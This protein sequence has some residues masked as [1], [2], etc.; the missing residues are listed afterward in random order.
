MP[1]GVQKNILSIHVLVD[2]LSRDKRVKFSF[3]LDKKTGADE[4]ES[5][6]IH[7]KLF[8]RDD[9]ADD[10]DDPTINIDVVVKTKN[11]EKMEVTAAK[12]FNQAQT[13]RTLVD[14]AT[15][16]DRVKAGKD[17]ETKLARSV[18]RVIE[19]RDRA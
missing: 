18:E 7:F 15:V 6:T 14:V 10:F 16:S 19:S 1:A 8:E 12:G 11:F 3:G 13:E 5:W 4:V 2:V 9:A 17:D